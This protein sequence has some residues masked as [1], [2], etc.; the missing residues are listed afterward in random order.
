MTSS[1]PGKLRFIVD[2]HEGVE[3]VRAVQMM[4][5]IIGELRVRPVVPGDIYP[6]LVVISGPQVPTPEVARWYIDALVEEA[7]T[8][9]PSYL[10]QPF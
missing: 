8:K 5:G 2:D 1:A 9:L 7:Q 10:R 4:L 6:A 3:T